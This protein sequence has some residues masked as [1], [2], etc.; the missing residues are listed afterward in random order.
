[1]VH[2]LILFKLL[3]FKT[4]KH[5]LN[6]LKNKNVYIIALTNMMSVNAQ[7][8]LNQQPVSVLRAL[9]QKMV[10]TPKNQEVRITISKLIDIKNGV[11]NITEKTQQTSLRI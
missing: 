4:K 3:F 1:M 5:F 7:L 9:L 11:A 8:A 2:V 10:D 6:D